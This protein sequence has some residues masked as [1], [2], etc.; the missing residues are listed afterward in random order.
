[1]A[2]LTILKPC[3]NC[4]FKVPCGGVDNQYDLFG[5]FSRCTS[6]AACRKSG[7][8]CPCRPAAWARRWNEVG[9]APM[10]PK[11]ARTLASCQ[12]DLPEYIPVIRHGSSRH[13][14]FS[15]SLVA[16]SSFDVLRRVGKEYGPRAS[17]A[18]SLRKQFGLRPDAAILLV[19]VGPDQ[20]LETYW[21]ERNVQRTPEALAKLNLVGM[22][23]PN[24]SF[25][26]DA[27]RPH[28]LWN[29][30]RMRVVA[31][32][33]SDAGLGV[34]PHL[35]AIT[36]ADWDYWR[37]F[38]LA[39]PHLRFVAKEFQTGLAS[40]EKGAHALEKLARVQDEIG[41]PLHPALIGGGRHFS[42]ANSLFGRC[43]IVDSVPFIRTVKRK[44]HYRDRQG[45][46]RWRKQETLEEEPLDDL[47]EH[48]VESYRRVLVS[49]E[50]TQRP[51]NDDRQLPLEAVNLPAA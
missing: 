22:S 36:D 25:F 35:N 45:Q 12:G 39:Q 43:S 51:G 42:L 17:S 50:V 14:T 10:K 33:L 18:E 24:Y 47:L 34:I 21:T 15:G 26:L 8:T 11:A 27:P 49:R 46:T 29:R 31:E 30:E 5:C 4:A 3:H 20:P 19:S 48:N 23:V 37:G 40:P 9:T 6:R 44:S 7:W 32:E 38:L 16:L 41:R 2:T 1:M 28:A 13:G